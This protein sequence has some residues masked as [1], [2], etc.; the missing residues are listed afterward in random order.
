MTEA[1]RGFWVA[2]ATPLTS[3]GSVDSAKLAAHAKQLFEKGVDGV[4]L[5]GTTGEGTS[6]NV[7]ERVATVEALLNAGVAAERI[8]IGGGFPAI[9]DSIALTRAVLGLGLRHVLFLPPYFDRNVTPDGIED[10][11]AAIIDR[12]GDD[13]LRA[14]L[15]HI[16]QISGVAIPTTVAAALRKR[17][18][19]LVAG[20]KDSSGDFKQFQAFRAA[21]P[22]L[23]ITVGNETDIARAIAGGGAGTICGMAN[24]AP[25]LVKA[26]IDG[27]DVEARMQAA[28]DIVVKSP[29]FLA[30]LK[31]ILAAQT[32]DAGWLRVRP[33]LRAL[34]D[35]A[36][37]KSKLDELTSPAI[38]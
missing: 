2:S 15:Y 35:G 9:S 10:A 16:P 14:V 21:S 5:F 32:G 18:G 24:I 11:F 31:A 13:R 22:E 23:A 37:L 19:K 30:T 29:S 6:F 3:D 25:E 8:G 1:I 17:Y 27:K 34:S 12:V 20:L 26:M 28:V 38:A 4:V 36:A 33:P 7:G